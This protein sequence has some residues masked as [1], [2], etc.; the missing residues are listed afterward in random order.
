[1]LHF[2]YILFIRIIGQAFMPGKNTRYS[3]KECYEN[4]MNDIDS[5]GKRIDKIMY[6]K[7]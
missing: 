4:T 2:S 3:L 5:Q 1:M 6:W 7:R